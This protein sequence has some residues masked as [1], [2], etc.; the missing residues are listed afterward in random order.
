M[1][2]SKSARLP[3]PPEQAFALMATEEFQDAKCVDA[4]AVKH[5]VSVVENGA[6]TVITAERTMP[7]DGLPDAAKSLVGP[8]ITVV[9]TQTW[10]PVVGDGSRTGRVELRA[11][12]VPMTMTGTLSL[13]PDGD[14]TQESIEADLKVAVPLMGGRLEKAAAP[15]IIAAIDSEIA[16]AQQR[17]SR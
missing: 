5:R 2:I 7:S 16:L 8:S 15:V 4:G 10:G 9:E 14:G 1:R 13:A 6:D 11:K 17:L 3:A 12:G